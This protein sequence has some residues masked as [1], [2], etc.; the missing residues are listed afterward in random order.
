[1]PSLFNCPGGSLDE[2][3]ETEESTAD[4]DVEKGAF[5]RE[6]GGQ[7]LELNESWRQ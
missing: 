7:E 2:R 6:N 4:G 1:M 5:D 3:G